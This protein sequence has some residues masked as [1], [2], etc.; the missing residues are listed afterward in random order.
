M[1][2]YEEYGNPGNPT[3][4]FLHGMNFTDTFRKSYCLAEKY[5]LV[6][7]HLYGYGKEVDKT[8]NTKDV[9]EAIIEL[10]KQ[11]NGE[12]VLIGFSL[13]AQI[14]LYLVTHYPYLFKGGIFISAWVDKNEKSVKKIMKPNL[15]SMK[16]LRNKRIAG[17]QGKILG[18]K[19]EQLEDFIEAVSSVTEETVMATVDNGININD[20]YEKFMG[21]SIPTMAFCGIREHS[22]VKNSLYRI[23]ELNGKCDTDLWDKAKHNI[24]MLY[25]NRLN[26]TIEEYMGKIFPDAEII[27]TDNINA[28]AIDND[29]ENIDNDNGIITDTSEQEQRSND[30][31]TLIENA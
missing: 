9:N 5:H 30:D 26:K 10:A 1:I 12:C 2:Y 3:I 19:G 6:I 24:P 21:L 11:Y 27:Y 22:E 7:P 31:E 16:I 29:N 28:D 25:S 17:F 23:A 20:F 4:I 8:F 13:G 18:L 15:M 14:A